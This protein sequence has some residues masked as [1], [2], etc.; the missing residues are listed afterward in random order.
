M[1]LR[2]LKPED[3]AFLAGHSTSGGCFRDMPKKAIIAKTLEHEGRLLASGGLALLNKDA[4]LVW[5]DIAEE[6]HQHDIAM[7]RQIRNWLD[8]VP[9]E[10]G[11]KCLMATIDSGFAAGIHLARH[12]GFYQTGTIPGFFGERGGLLFV[13]NL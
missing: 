9:K 4:A 2:D 1:I 6:G 7:Y 13:R 3:I 11:L 10:L 12:L 5:L 8:T